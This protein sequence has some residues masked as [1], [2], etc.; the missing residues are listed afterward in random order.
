MS[1][2]AAEPVPGAPISGAAYPPALDAHHLEHATFGDAALAAELLGLFQG[3]CDSLAPVI[4]GQGEALQVRIDAAH[5]LKGGARAIG[6]LAV[7]DAAARVEQGLRDHA[8]LDP[9]GWQHLAEAIAEA[10]RV[11]AGRAQA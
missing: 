7:A 6:A 5:T 3:Q 1:K 8:A 9:E 2:P 11:I 4:A 10:K